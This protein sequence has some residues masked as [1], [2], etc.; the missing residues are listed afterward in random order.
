M[1]VKDFKPTEFSA[2]ARLRMAERG[3]TEAEVEQ[4]IREGGRLPVRSGRFE[5]RL[6]LPYN[7]T[8]QGKVYAVKQIVALVAEEPDRFVVVT[9]YTFY[10]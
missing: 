7:R 9:V 5:C 2:H 1:N 8:W 10:F 6:N 3:A 4:A